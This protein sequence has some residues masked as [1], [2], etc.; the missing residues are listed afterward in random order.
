MSTAAHGHEQMVIASELDGM[1]HI[2]NI[3]AS[4][5]QS[6]VFIN[7]PVPD[8]AAG[9]IAPVVRADQFAMQMGL[10]VPAE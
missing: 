6:R 4:H 3:S 2:D 5:D 9:V 10:E 7:H 1:N 8:L